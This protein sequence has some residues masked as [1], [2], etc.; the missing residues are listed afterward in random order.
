[1][2]ILH[3][4][5]EHL[6]RIRISVRLSGVI[7]LVSETDREIHRGI[8]FPYLQLSPYFFFPLSVS[9][10]YLLPCFFRFNSELSIMHSSTRWHTNLPIMHVR[11][12]CDAARPGYK[13]ML[14]LSST[15]LVFAHLHRWQV[16]QTVL[17]CAVLKINM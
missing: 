14:R 5:V 6:P 17:N 15:V 4:A 13:Y 7:Y 11:D 3:L 16:F 2:F 9:Y 1:M 10:L 12:K 8:I